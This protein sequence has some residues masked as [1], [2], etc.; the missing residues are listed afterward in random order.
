M[1]SSQQC[2]QRGNGPTILRETHRWSRWMEIRQLVEPQSPVYNHDA[3]GLISLASRLLM[4][5]F[6]SQQITLFLLHQTN[7]SSGVLTLLRTAFLW[8]EEF[9][10]LWRISRM[11]KTSSSWMTLKDEVDASCMIQR[12]SFTEGLPE[13]WS[14]S[15]TFI[16]INIAAGLLY[17]GHLKHSIHGMRQFYEPQDQK[18]HTGPGFVIHQLQDWCGGPSTSL[19]CSSPLQN[20]DEHPNRLSEAMIYIKSLWKQQCSTYLSMSHYYWQPMN[21]KKRLCFMVHRRVKTHKRKLMRKRD[22]NNPG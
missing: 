21:W 18:F 6:E 1:G 10:A 7:L 2:S 17:S 20:R 11:K 16:I 12:G 3:G 4:Q 8:F 5:Y 14:F 9:R 15:P 13:S 22:L 19:S